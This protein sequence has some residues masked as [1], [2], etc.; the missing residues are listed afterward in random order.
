[1]DEEGVEAGACPSCRGSGRPRSSTGI[2]AVVLIN[3][4]FLVLALRNILD[5]DRNATYEPLPALID[6]S[7]YVV[8]GPM[9][10][11]PFSWHIWT[12]A[13]LLAE[14]IYETTFRLHGTIVSCP[15]PAAPTS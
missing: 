10:L 8:G 13:C 11:W 3:I 12:T 6:R 4:V 5:E 14:F 1:V 7:F 2:I 9:A 15:S